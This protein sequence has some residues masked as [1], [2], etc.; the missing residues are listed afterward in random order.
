MNQVDTL[1]LA[2]SWAGLFAIVRWPDKRLGLVLSTIFF[3]AAIYTQ[4]TYILVA[5]VTAL[6]W[7][8]Q[9]RRIRQAVMLLAG[10]VGASLV[11]F[12]GLNSFTRGGFFFNLITVN[13][14]IWNFQ[15]VV[16]EVIDF[17]FH[18]VPLGLIVLTFLIAERLYY[19]T[20]S[21]PF[22]LPYYIAAILITLLVGKAGS[23]EGYMF[24]LSAA[25]CLVAGAAIAWATNYWAKA[26]VLVLLAIQVGSFLTWNSEQ[27][28]PKFDE[29]IANKAEIAQL[30]DMVRQADGPILI[31]EY[32]GL[33]PLAGKGIYYA[34]FEFKQ[35]LQAGL[36]DPTPLMQ[37][38][39]QHKFASLL[40]YFPKDI[41]IMKSRWPD[42]IY[43][44][45][46]DYYYNTDYLADTLIFH[47]K[48]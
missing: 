32:N 10:V 33:L 35:L 22:V 2:L 17:S 40:I 15:Q 45:M 12:L 43:S 27:F 8:L 7:L 19:P 4:H 34:P 36:W 16:G 13:A 5:P 11:L 18:T 28:Q 46:V 9:T 47:P 6:A 14:N 29:K 24:E 20:R 39:S 21:W 38:L 41:S 48:K 23:N 26:A 44:K 42:N 30:A 25:L 31:D 1:A 37:D 3:T